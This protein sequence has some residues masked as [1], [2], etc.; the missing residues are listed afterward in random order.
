MS[1]L[2]RMQPATDCY[3]KWPRRW[4]LRRAFY[5]VETMAHVELDYLLRLGASDGLPRSRSIEASRRPRLGPTM[6]F[7]TGVLRGRNDGSC[8]AGLLDRSGAG[9]LVSRAFFFLLKYGFFAFPLLLITRGRLLRDRTRDG[10]E[11][12][13][14]SRQTRP[15]KRSHSQSYLSER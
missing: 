12:Y 7:A 15:C 4:L 3:A 13:Y 10:D 11:S 8:G 6:A 9:D 14:C 1:L 2:L 5:E